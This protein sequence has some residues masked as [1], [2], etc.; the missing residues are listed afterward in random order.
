MSKGFGIRGS[1]KEKTIKLLYELSMELDELAVG[2][3]QILVGLEKNPNQYPFEQAEGEYL[4]QRR[5]FSQLYMGSW[6]L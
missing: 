5:N 3:I 6:R 4:R 2:W 1:E